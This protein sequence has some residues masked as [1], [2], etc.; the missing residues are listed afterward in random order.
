MTQL[1]V[2]A[3]SFPFGIGL[4]ARLSTSSPSSFD[5]GA[6]LRPY[7]FAGFDSFS[8][9]VSAGPGGLHAAVGSMR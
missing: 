9:T 7:V 8:G 3:F 4:A 2:G 1:A 6:D 5:P